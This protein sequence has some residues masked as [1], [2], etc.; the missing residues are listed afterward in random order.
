VS[1]KASEEV[2]DELQRCK[3]DGSKGKKK[4]T[5]EAKQVEETAETA[6]FAGNA[7]AFI[8]DNTS[9]T[10]AL[11]V[12]ASSDW[13]ADTGASSHMTPHCHW[14]SSYC[15]FQIHVHHANGQT[16]VSAGVGAVW[17]RPKRP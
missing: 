16:I 14:F 7:S 6:E 4:K 17:F 8:P 1:C 9:P 5:Q 12:E 15:P 11:I 13:T 2:K 10:S 3:A